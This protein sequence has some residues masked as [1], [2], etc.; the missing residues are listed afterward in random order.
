MTKKLLGLVCT[1]AVAFVLIGSVTGCGDDKK[2]TTTTT[3]TTDK[4]TD[5]KAP[6]R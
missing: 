5:D 2:K 3:T 1:A 4:K 6:T